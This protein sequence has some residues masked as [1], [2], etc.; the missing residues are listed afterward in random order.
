ME[1]N[2]LKK[3]WQ[4]LLKFAHE[5]IKVQIV[6]LRVKLAV[7]LLGKKEVS[8]TYVSQNGLKMKL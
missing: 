7:K 2:F 8:F 3:K 5:A 4:K 1:W 6:L